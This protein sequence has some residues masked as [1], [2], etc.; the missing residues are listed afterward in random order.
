MEPEVITQGLQIHIH[1]EQRVSGQVFKPTGIPGSS[2]YGENTSRNNSMFARNKLPDHVKKSLSAM[3][4]YSKASGTWS[5]YRTAERMLLMCQKA[6]KVV[7]EMPLQ[8]DNIYL[9]IHWLIEERGLKVAT[10]N[11]Y[12]A[13]IRNLHISRGIEPPV[14]RDTWVKEVLRGREN[15]EAAETR[16]RGNNSK[17]RLPMT[18]S[19][20]KL[21]RARIR[22]S[23]EKEETQRLI[24]SVS[25]LAFYG[26]FRIHELV[27]KTES[28]FDPDNT[29]LTENLK[30]VGEA[31]N[32]WLEITL[33]CP[34]EKKAGRPTIIDVFETGGPLCPVMAY[35]KWTELNKPD[36]GMPLFREK[37]GTPMTGRRIN[38]LLKTLLQEYSS[39]ETGTISSHSFRSGIVSI[40]GSKGFSDEEIKLV[41]RWSSRAFIRYMKLPRTQQAAIAKRIGN[42]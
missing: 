37:N 38:T 28:T 12:L 10:V 19:L 8:A 29:L 31:G 18:I 24:W 4:N 20:M 7:F 23:N 5:S 14:I 21:W 22:A 39:F 3:C 26:A 6:H 1:N 2:K 30:M 36:L 33:K 13:G 32:R 16:R 40:L 25:T 41:G 9:F 27:S 42:L 35:L 34:K 17:G 11:S 15:Y